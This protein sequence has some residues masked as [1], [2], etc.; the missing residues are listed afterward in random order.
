V[1]FL[2]NWQFGAHVPLASLLPAG[3]CVSIRYPELQATLMVWGKISLERFRSIDWVALL[4]VTDPVASHCTGTHSMS[5]SKLQ[6]EHFIVY[7][8][9]SAQLMNARP[10]APALYPTLHVTVPFL[11]NS[12]KFGTTA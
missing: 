9:S 7:V 8:V 5:A 11:P 2:D 12:I 4:S 10:L 3:S 1:R 6:P